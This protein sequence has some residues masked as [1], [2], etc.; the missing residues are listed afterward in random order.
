MSTSRQDVAT[1]GPGWNKVLLNY[2]LAMQALDELPIANRNS[3]KFLGAMH[4]FRRQLWIDEHVIKAT[5]TIP[6]DLT[7]DTYGNQCQHGSWYFVSWHRAYL[8]AFESIVAAKVKELTGDDWALPYWNYLNSSNPDARQMPDA[9]LAK[10][11]PNGAPNPL[12]K[13]PRRPG[14]TALQPG[15]NDGFSLVAMDE[16]DFLVGNDGTLGFGGGITG[17][18]EQFDGMTG[19][20]EGNPH[21]TVHRL[22]GGA[23]GFM[24]NALL[25]GLDPI[26]WL[27]HCN[28]D[29][30]WE[31]WMNTPG[32]TMVRDPRWF[33]GPADRRFIMPVPGGDAPGVTFTS[34]DTLK[35]GKY[36][37]AY[38]DLIS[39]TGVTPGE[40]SVARVKMGLPNQQTIQPIGANAAVVTVGGTPAHTHIDLEPLATTKSMATMGATTPGNEVARL[41]L[42]LESVR[43]TAPSPLLEVY[44]NLPEGADPAL[45]PDRHAGSLTL[46]GLNVASEPDG[47]HA[48]NGLGY[49]IDITDLA[50]RLT[51][52]GDFDPNHLRVTLVPG[53]QISQDQPVTVERISVLK[54]SGVVS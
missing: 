39:G 50:Q 8:F 20:L 29:R 37:R 45:H 4:G 22:I 6:T 11:L 5:D 15:P 51:S 41:Y 19:D 38:D 32:K 46:F 44:V 35:G 54:R 42:S 12:N 53:E 40:E 31:A 24:G 27:H 21:N 14:F 18:F 23:Q 3:W 16:N 49:T 7:N 1:L 28:I 36:Y 52:A 13:Y 30:L 47:P 43:G 48:G 17:N 33:E 25:A 2:A 34:Q 26:F 9:F 10:T